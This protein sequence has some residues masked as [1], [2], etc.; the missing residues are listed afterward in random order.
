LID[1]APRQLQ[2]VGN[3]ANDT[4]DWRTA[5]ASLGVHQVLNFYRVWRMGF[6]MPPF[7]LCIRRRLCRKSPKLS[8]KA[9]GNP[10]A[11]LSRF[12]HRPFREND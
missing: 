6:F 11:T 7:L 12:R 5:V 10:D 3:L 2:T 4:C 8:A 9:G 1:P